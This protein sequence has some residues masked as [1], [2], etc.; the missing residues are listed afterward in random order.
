MDIILMVFST[1]INV[2]T[3]LLALRF[4]MQLAA[5]DPYNPVVMSTIRATYVVDVFSRILP[6]VAQ[7][8]M[9]LAALMLI[10][11]LQ[12]IDLWGTNLLTGQPPF[13]ALELL[14]VAVISLLSSFL[15]FCKWLIIGS[16]I[17]SWVVAFTQ[18]QSPYI[19]VVMQMTEPL[20]APFRRIMPD[21][22]PIDLSPMVAF[23]AIIIC[24]HLL[25]AAAVT[26]LAMV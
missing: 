14:V 22:G 19:G 11:L 15:T 4:M 3:L 26:L 8:R 12:L 7:G 25:G 16:I 20:L 24:Q 17:L 13:G 5:V 9:S 23:L 18:S 1:I 6:N 2:A 10:T 21:L